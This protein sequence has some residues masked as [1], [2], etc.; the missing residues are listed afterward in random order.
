MRVADLLFPG[1]GCG[2]RAAGTHGYRGLYR[3]TVTGRIGGLSRV[4][5]EIATGALL[6]RAVP[7]RPSR[8]RPTRADRAA[9]TAP[10]LRERFLH[11]SDVRRAD[12]RPDAPPRP[13]GAVPHRP[14]HR[15]GTVPGR[16]SGTRLSKRMS[17]STCKDTLLRL[18]R[19]LPDPE[20]GPVP[21]RRRRVRPAPPQDLRVEP[22]QHDHPS[23]SRRSGRPDR[24][25][26]RDLAARSSRGAGHLPRPGRV[27]SRRG[28][29]RRPSGQAGGRHLASGI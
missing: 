10:R 1:C 6:L 3:L 12:T 2:G 25:N 9:G 19:A 16:P 23:P 13:P 4:R 20:P 15:R 27:L 28:Q 17:I 18:I 29:F 22:D 24:R 7:G 11:P 14:A 26:L 8:R 5:A 21:P